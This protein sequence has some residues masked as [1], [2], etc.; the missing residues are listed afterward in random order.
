MR[1]NL[2]IPIQNIKYQ[3]EH[4]LKPKHSDNFHMYARVFI[5][6]FKTYIASLG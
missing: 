5:I 6:E 2:S 4:R 1:E 3:Y